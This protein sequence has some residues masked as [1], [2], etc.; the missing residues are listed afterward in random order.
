[1][2]PLLWIGALAVVLVVEVLLLWPRCHTLT[3]PDAPPERDCTNYP[4]P[5]VLLAVIA[6]FLGAAALRVWSSPD[7]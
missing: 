2:R 6:V 3:F 5:A 7:P 4:V 1:V